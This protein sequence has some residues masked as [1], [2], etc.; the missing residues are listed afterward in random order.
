MSWVSSMLACVQTLFFVQIFVDEWCH[1]FSRTGEHAA[2]SDV[3]KFINQVGAERR[4]VMSGTPTTGDEDSPNFTAKGLD[5]LQR[6]LLFLRHEKYGTTVDQFD[7]KNVSSLSVM[8]QDGNK[9]T[10]KTAWDKHVKKPFLNKQEDGR[11]ELYRVL[12]EVMIMHKKEDLSLPKPIFKQSQI[13]VL[14]PPSIQSAIIDILHSTKRDTITDALHK[15]GITNHQQQQRLSSALTE[16]GSTLFDALFEEYMYT[17]SFQALVDDGQ[18][19][20]I[21]DVIRKEQ[22]ALAERGGAVV[23]IGNTPITAATQL[24]H[25]SENWVDRRPI[26]AVV[27][28]NS[29]KYLLSVAEYL[30]AAFD[31]ENIA[32]M[33]EGEFRL[34]SREKTIFVASSHALTIL[35]NS[36]PSYDRQN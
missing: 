16:G 27:Y 12:D 11:K 7:G 8:V 24:A 17:D 34:I 21:I 33:I 4:W 19:N 26:K 9:W 25:S 30:Y 20:F 13:D 18:A 36:A 6:L 22:L 32:E 15:I 31:N 2:G 28:S 29:H 35:P 14:I 5:Q 1:L 3:T 10:A 23:G